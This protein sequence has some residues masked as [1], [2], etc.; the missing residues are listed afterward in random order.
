[1]VAKT[2]NKMHHIHHT[3][4]GMTRMGSWY[5]IWETLVRHGSI[6]IK[7][8][9]EVGVTFIKDTYVKFIF[10]AFQWEFRTNLNLQDNIEKKKLDDSNEGYVPKTELEGLLQ[11]AMTHVVGLAKLLVML[12][13]GLGNTP[14]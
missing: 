1:M 4:Y 9:S 14:Q 11:H 3:S 6:V 10:K 12:K 2:Y 5:K 8:K 7:V 13:Q